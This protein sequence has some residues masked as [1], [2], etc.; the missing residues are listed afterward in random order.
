[1]GNDV[2]HELGKQKPRYCVLGFVDMGRVGFVVHQIGNKRCPRRVVKVCG[3][4]ISV[5]VE[6]ASV[7]CVG[8]FTC[9]KGLEGK[10]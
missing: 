1:M 8:R 7:Y 5:L 10:Q 6:L 9:S 2:A 3:D 4:S